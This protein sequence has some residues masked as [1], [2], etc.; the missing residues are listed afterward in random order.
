M[1]RLVLRWYLIGYTERTLRHDWRFPTRKSVKEDKLVF[2]QIESL[3]AGEMQ[4]Q[5]GGG[6]EWAT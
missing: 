2:L 3:R 5:E 6:A 4:V 1:P